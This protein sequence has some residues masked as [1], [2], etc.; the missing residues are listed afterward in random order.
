MKSSQRYEAAASA[1]EREFGAS[2]IETAGPAIS[3]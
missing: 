2:M 3:M 1:F